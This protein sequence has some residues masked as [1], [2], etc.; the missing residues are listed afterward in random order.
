M[1]A[2]ALL[3]A[4][5]TTLIFPQAIRFMVDGLAGGETP[6]SL[7]TGAILLVLLFLVQSAF[8]MLRTWLFTASGER[9][10]ASLR[11]ALGR[12]DQL[13]RTRD[14]CGCGARLLAHPC[15]LGAP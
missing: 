4:S 12:C 13:L 10:V 2:V 3:I 11:V 8:A 5:G 15:R 9:I 14:E 1:A 7:N 6:L